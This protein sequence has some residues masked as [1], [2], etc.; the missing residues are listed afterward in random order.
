MSMHEY[1]QEAIGVL[2]YDS[3]L[4]EFLTED[5]MPLDD[6]S[7]YAYSHG[8]VQMSSDMVGSYFL[9]LRNGNYREIENLRPDHGQFIG[10]CK[11]AA[12]MFEAAYPDM[13][14]LIT[15]LKQYY[16]DFVPADFPWEERVVNFIGTICC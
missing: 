14:V 10:Q 11:R 2:F 13:D 5:N 3:E 8:V 9:I 12:M 7:D 4:A 6:F 15:E 1:A 16:G